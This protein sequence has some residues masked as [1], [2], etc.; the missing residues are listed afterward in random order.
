MKKLY[1]FIILY[2]PL[3]LFSQ[4][5]QTPDFCKVSIKNDTPVLFW[6]YEDTSSI[7]GFIIKRIIL[8]GTGVVNGT[9]NNIA[10][11]PKN[12]TSFKDTSSAYQTSA[13]PYIR[14]ETYALSAFRTSNDSTYFSN[15]SPFQKTLFLQTNWDYCNT[16][17]FFSWNK[18][19]NRQVTEYQLLYSTDS[20]NFKV[21]KIFVTDTT[22]QTENLQKNITYYFRVMAILANQNHCEKDTS[23]SNIVKIFTASPTLPHKFLIQYVSTDENNKIHIKLSSDSLISIQKIRMFRNDSLHEETENIS[24][25]EFTDNSNFKSPESYHFE[26]VDSCGNITA[27]TSEVR[28]ICLKAKQTN[29]NF[30][31]NFNKTK[32][33]EQEINSYNIEYSI[34]NQWTTLSTVRNVNFK[35]NKNE[36]YKKTNPPED[37]RQIK[38]RVSCTNDSIIVYSNTVAVL[39]DAFIV[40]PNSFMPD[41]PNE[42]DRFFCLKAHFIN[43]FEITI[44]NDKNQ[45]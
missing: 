14:C 17:A 40:A 18:Y 31:L 21:L 12:F 26:A 35:L 39:P 13:K 36:F 3:F 37:L 10:I 29:E 11:L 45:M 32:I 6:N 19:I 16:T 33:N 27:S 34:D 8:D 5:P 7:D 22:Y 9:L 30:I 43:D 42:T 20:T 38:F 4:S 2:F 41:S 15:I 28:N 1:F 23:Y 44:F 25:T 24:E